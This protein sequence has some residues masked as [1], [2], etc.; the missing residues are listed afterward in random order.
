MK[1]AMIS[2][3]F[4]LFALAACA[5]A[6]EE[7]LVASYGDGL[8]PVFSQ[9]A[10]S[11][12]DPA[13]KTAAQIIA[14]ARAA[15]GRAPAEEKPGPGDLAF[16]PAP[17][18]GGADESNTQVAS[19]PRRVSKPANEAPLN[20]LKPDAE[21]ATEAPL[22][23]LKPDAE[24]PVATP[25]QDAEPAAEAPMNFL[26]PIVEAAAEVTEKPRQSAAL[27]LEPTAPQPPV[28][29]AEQSYQVQLAAYRKPAGA[30]A[31]WSVLSSAYPDL[32][33]GLSKTVRRADLG[34]TRGVVH[35]LRVGSFSDEAKARALCETLKERGADCFTVVQR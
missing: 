3:V 26:K 33:A 27:T 18:A 4:G 29:A 9:P 11:T 10:A 19:L 23:L 17:Q 14:E 34:A 28:R 8:A 6:S 1:F 20:L 2:A 30:E 12:D 32:F 15:A 25:G 13:Q 21:A 7:T 35:Q 22:N 24:P 5:G 16:S 31:A